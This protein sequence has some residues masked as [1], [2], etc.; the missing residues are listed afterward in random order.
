MSDATWEIRIRGPQLMALGLTSPP[1]AWAGEV[2]GRGVVLARTKGAVEVH[3][4][5]LSA[6]P[7]LRQVTDRRYGTIDGAI[8]PD[9]RWV[10]WFDDEAGD[11][12]GRWQRE[13]FDGGYRQA[14]L[15]DLPASESTG[16][17]P[18]N[19]GGAIVARWSD[20]LELAVAHPDGT[21]DVVFSQDDWSA[22]DDVSASG[23]LALL[24]TSPADDAAHT[25]VLVVSLTDGAVVDTLAVPDA[26][27]T[28]VA[29]RPGTNDTVLVLD[30]SGERM[31]LAL[32]HLTS[33]D[34]TPI[35]TGLGGDLHA[36]WSRDGSWLVVTSFENG[37]E[38]VHRHDLASG[39]T[40]L[41]R[42]AVGVVGGMSVD[43]DDCVQLL[44]SSSDQPARLLLIP[45]DGSAADDA[46]NPLVLIDPSAG[47]MPPTPTSTDVFTDGPG[48]RI[49]SLL[50]E[51]S[52]GTRPFPTVFWVHGGPWWRDEH[53]WR[54]S[55]PSLTDA[56][57]AVVRV[58]F[59]GST[60]YGTAWQDALHRD[61]GAIEC[62]DIAAVREA[63]VRDG[64]IDPKRVAI[65]GGS[66]GGYVTLYALGTQPDAW[67]AG[68][69]LVPL[70]DWAL[71]W[72]LQP[73][74][75]R[76]GDAALIGGRLEDVPELFAAASPITYV[77]DVRAPVL[78]TAGESDPHCPV[79]QVDTYVER[80]QARGHDVTYDRRT[81]GH[82][83]WDADTRVAE[84]RTFVDFLKSKLI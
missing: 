34:L 16:I 5:D 7:T 46:S 82:V 49:H 9:G 37:R 15:T 23:D 74:N 55:V 14:L 12:V 59:R 29:F 63:L 51:P 4:F 52:T 22:L 67:V 75:W 58:N 35:R 30:E 60:G 8:S 78:I 2:Q 44:E 19:N 36:K 81:G 71:C 61:I 53:A 79:Q 43:A 50:T 68:A 6:E 72:E 64:V 27:L 77:D 41:L 84:T 70:A 54:D 28:A 38:S 20:H 62:A 32:W 83:A 25:R 24:T 65:G 42:P 39:V 45:S 76:A 10:F 11:E 66:W 69:A 21:G 56:G 73:A 57:I 48:G 3:T 26:R 17:V 1:I 31:G 13:P 47:Q 33:N 18:R 40:T 80:L